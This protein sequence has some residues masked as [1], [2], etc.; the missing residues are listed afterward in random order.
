MKFFLLSQTFLAIRSC[1]YFCLLTSSLSLFSSLPAQP[2]HPL[3]VME[4]W[5]GWF[6]HWGE[7][8]LERNI[9]PEDFSL[10]LRA[11]L[12]EGASVNLY[13]FHG[14]TN[15]GFMNGGNWGE[16]E[17]RGRT[18]RSTVSS[19]GT[20]RRRDYC[21]AERAHLVVLMRES[22]YLYVHVVTCTA[23]PHLP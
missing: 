3:M 23:A 8:H 12:A 10:E 14:G 1:T 5:T 17:E 4:F 18:Y 20:L 11:I 15:S 16:G 22:I 7:K 6:D 2:H 19:Y 13:M 21:R 9:S